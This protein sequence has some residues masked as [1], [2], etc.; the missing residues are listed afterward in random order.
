MHM[1]VYRHVCVVPGI[2]HAWNERCSF[3]D[4]FKSGCKVYPLQCH[5]PHGR[6]S[7]TAQ[8]VVESKHFSYALRH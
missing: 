6:T 5:S 2:R 7:S 1:F 4:R 3:S 8:N